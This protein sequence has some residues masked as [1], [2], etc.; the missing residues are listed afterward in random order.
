M[1]LQ[2]AMQ[3]RSREMWNGGLEGIEAIIERQERVLA[4]GD[5]Q[6]F[7]RFAE[8][9]RPR[10]SGSHPSIAHRT[11]SAPFSSGLG[12]DAVAAASTLRLA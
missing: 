3:R 2:A 6:R 8:H 10:L 9:C 11:T 12:I 4:K 5:D 1:P 7:F